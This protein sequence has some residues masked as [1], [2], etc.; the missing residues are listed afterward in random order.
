MKVT[1][2]TLLSGTEE[3]PI[4]VVVDAESAFATISWQYKLT[5]GDGD[6]RSCSN[7]YNKSETIE[8]TPWTNCDSDNIIEGNLTWN[9]LKVYYKIT[10]KKAIC[11]DSCDDTL[12]TIEYELIEDMVWVTPYEIYCNAESKGIKLH[13]EYYQI[14]KLCDKIVKR[15]KIKKDIPIEATCEC[16]EQSSLVNETYPAVEG[17]DVNYKYMC[18]VIEQEEC[19][20]RDM[21][22]TPI[23]V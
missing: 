14:T 23:N 6:C 18:I 19:V 17:F 9:T 1:Y 15:E 21:T 7:I 2:Y 20:C 13:Y 22:I 8:I 12:P 11:D 4:K 5:I 3:N 16:T 10:Q